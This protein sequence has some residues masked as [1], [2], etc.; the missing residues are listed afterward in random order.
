LGPSY[1]PV[2]WHGI[3]VAAS[4]EQLLDH[5]PSEASALAQA[6]EGGWEQVRRALLLMT[7]LHDLGKFGPAFQMKVPE[8]GGVALELA[9]GEM[10]RFPN[11]T[12]N[13]G[14]AGWAY[15]VDETWLGKLSGSLI[16]R[17]SQGQRTHI[18][19]AIFGHHGRPVGPQEVGDP[20]ILGKSQ[21]PSSKAAS[22]AFEALREL[23]GNPSFPPMKRGADAAFSLRLAGLV[24][25]ADWLGS[26]QQFFPYAPPG[27]IAAYW[28]RARKQAMVAL[29]ESGLLPTAPSTGA[30]L[31]VVTA[32]AFAPTQ[33]QVWADRVQLDTAGLYILEDVM[34]SGKT[35]AALILA[36]RLVQ[37]GAARG[38]Y[39]ALPTMATA[40]A[41]YRR[42]AAL[43]RRLF[44]PG[45]RP[46]LILAHGARDLDPHF[47]ASL[48]LPS[49][50]SRSEEAEDPSE[51]AC[52]RWLAD[53]RRKTFLA[54][55]GVG[56]ID[57]A[58]LG[59][60]P[61]KH[62]ALRQLGLRQ[63][64]LI[65]DEVH[66]Y[67]A[68][69]GRL[70]ESLVAHQAIMGAPVILLSATLP[71]RLKARLMRAWQ[72][73]RGLAP[74]DAG[75]DEMAYPLATALCGETIEARAFA[76]RADLVRE[77]TIRRLEDHAA[78]DRLVIEA[79]GQGAA[80][81]R[82]CNTVDEA[83][84]TYQRLSAAGVDAELFHAR[85]AMV[86]R[87]EV[88]T[89]AL[90]RFGKSSTPEERRGKVLVA[91]QVIEQSLDLDF[92]L[93]VS[94]LAPVD[95]LMQRAGR[96]WRHA[97]RQGRGWSVPELAVLSPDPA[98]GADAH[99]VGRLFP[100]G[101]YVYRDHA[102]LWRTACEI[103]G[104]Q[105][106]RLPAQ[107]RPLIEAVYAEVDDDIPEGLRASIVE[108]EGK[109]QASRSVAGYN[110]LD[111]SK[112]YS[113]ASGA[114][115]P[116][117]NTPTRESD[118]RTLIRLARIKGET[119]VPYAVDADPH[120]AWALSE[121]S[122]SKGRI[123]GR[124]PCSPAIEAAAKRLEA[125]WERHHIRALCLPLLGDGESGWELS[126][127]GRE[128]KVGYN[129]TIGLAKVDYAR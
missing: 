124:G 125:E 84:A 16:Q 129:P 23:F 76:P 65:I 75:A 97:S 39:V 38:L 107:I 71:S 73:A 96:V 27:D 69:V 52:A 113:Q 3:D 13:H 25:L 21:S 1:H 102:R 43:Y 91:T 18:F 83:I 81:A 35:E 127:V 46:S 2:T 57:Q 98:E 118:A 74:N 112:G 89:R 22:A 9:V 34:G 77:L 110:A 53:D 122:V 26:N 61:V 72:R 126:V 55:V 88:E 15:L 33:A 68:Y 28:E 29:A 51:A 5:W 56:T 79:A 49:G 67:D 87:I 45:E 30:S 100:K 119:L 116:E 64:V 31:E 106:L 54:D 80:V 7:A 82:L 109:S 47:R 93:M 108:S 42:M 6:F 90:A 85:F 121:L 40:N 94:D 44:A 70:L 99:W 24:T 12:F 128:T 14:E 123:A 114:W 115:N 92:D 37:A 63:R 117:I 78:A 101:Q 10:P 59:V 58:L 36:H 4:L 95:V 105:I 48:G 120:R 111:F 11:G 32:S 17:L 50:T 41:L 8:L 66:S 20:R 104:A 19:Q 103:F 86:D 62:G 60:M